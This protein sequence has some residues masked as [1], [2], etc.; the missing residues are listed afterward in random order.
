LF[1][2]VIK[3]EELESYDEQDESGVFRDKEAMRIQFRLMGPLGQAHNII[4]YI[5]GLASRTE[6]F[7]KLVGRMIPMDNRIRWN[8]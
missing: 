2:D 6:E 1:I 8:S 7:R 4:V 5:R 3:L